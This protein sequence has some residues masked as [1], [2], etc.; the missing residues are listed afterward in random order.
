MK[1]VAIVVLLC[2]LAT[3]A[4]AQTLCLGWKSFHPGYRKMQL[5]A[6]SMKPTIEPGHCY[7]ARRHS[8]G[9]A[10]LPGQ[11]VL[12]QHPTRN[13]EFIKRIVAV[14][15]QSVQM[16]VGRLWIDGAP[17]P[18]V[19]QDKPYRQLFQPEGDHRQLPRCPE[20]VAIG[21]TCDIEIWI[22]T[23]AGTRY[24]TL[25][26]GDAPQ[27]NSEKFTVPEGHVFVLGDNRDNSTDSRMPQLV[28][29][30]GFVPISNIRAVMA[31]EDSS[32]EE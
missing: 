21:E 32:L 16:V 25:D 29:G 5:V 4:P 19:K 10:F 12:F 1:Q 31:A 3:S 7:Y 23:L 14:A 9:K 27:D 15:G 28:G 24:Q 6:G 13:V 30:L 20:P 8:E 26:L 17:V 18:A 22:E 2:V 11:V